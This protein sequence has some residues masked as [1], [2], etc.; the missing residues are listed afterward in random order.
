MFGSI[1]TASFSFMLAYVFWRAASLP[2]LTRRV[3]QKGIFN[4]GLVLWLLFLLSRLI[5]HN[6]AGPLAFFL[7][8][9]G[10][11]LMG[12]MLIIS[13]VLMLVDLLTAFGLLLPKKKMM[14]RGL[15]LAV[16]ILLS[17]IAL[18]QG[19]RP[20]EAVSY[21]VTLKGLPAELDGKVIV[22]VSDTHIGA[23]IGGRWLARRMGEIKA[24]KPD[25][26]VFVGDIFEG[27][28][29]APPD[30]PALRDLVPP[31]GKWFVNGNHESHG[32]GGDGNAILER[33]GF[34]HLA[35]QWA[36]ADRGL[37]IAGVNDLTNHKRRNL[38]GEPLA[39]TLNNMPQSATVL[40]S[41]TPWQADRA[42]RA[43]V[44][45]M[46]SGHTHGGQIWPF[47]YLV[48]MTYPLFAGRYDVD[49]MTVIVS[50]GAGT[51]GPRMRLWHRGE[52]VKVIIH[53]SPK[54][55]DEK[56]T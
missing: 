30:I 43:G 56:N 46:I 41:H 38:D 22:A 25:I 15:G 16:G 28:G 44:G 5:G 36:L 24:L 50:R 21:D 49:G 9:I 29:D 2:V 52:I 34:R 23:L 19:L 3:S 27:H 13:T 51:W 31:M 47:G 12:I 10:M 35:N 40:L 4:I 26:L 54:P 42:A 17:C 37:I 33:A 45:V 20:P 7:E 11:H 32:T 1:L 8:I 39:E 18:V 53:S 55:P 14:F 48:K 6:G